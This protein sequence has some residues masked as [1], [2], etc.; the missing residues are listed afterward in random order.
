MDGVVIDNTVARY[1]S[2]GDFSRL[3]YAIQ[4]AMTEAGLNPSD[5]RQAAEFIEN[6][7]K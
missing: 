6:F 5:V 2:D 7:S 4:I 1:Q 3:V